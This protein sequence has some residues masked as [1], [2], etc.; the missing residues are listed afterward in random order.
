M[1]DIEIM[2]FIAGVMIGIL[3]M[4][5]PSKQE[6]RH[7]SFYEMFQRNLERALWAAKFVAPETTVSIP[8]RRSVVGGYVVNC[9][10]TVARVDEAAQ[11]AAE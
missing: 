9:Q 1:T 5:T 2:C 8:L 11:E 10:I 7:R 3:A 6:Q 4:R